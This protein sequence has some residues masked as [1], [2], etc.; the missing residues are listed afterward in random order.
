MDRRHRVAGAG[1]AGIPDLRVEL[2]EVAVTATADGAA[3]VLAHGEARGT[4]DGRLYGA[5]ATH[6]RYRA[7]YFDRVRVVD[8]LIVERVQ[9]ADVLGQMRQLYGR[10]LGAVGLSAMLWRLPAP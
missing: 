8:G 9:Q 4:A 5:P 7:S 3:V 1:L 2:A 6:R 10:A